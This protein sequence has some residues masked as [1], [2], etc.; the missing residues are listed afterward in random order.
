[1][2]AAHSESEATSEQY[3]ET[4][5]F[6]N[7]VLTSLTV[8]AFRDRRQE[9][10]VENAWDMLSINF[11]L[12]VTDFATSHDEIPRITCRWRF[13]PRKEYRQASD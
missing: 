9:D 1:M 11:S 2:L 4:V 6:R 12:I 7:F 3:F 13:V 10:R 8:A 5:R